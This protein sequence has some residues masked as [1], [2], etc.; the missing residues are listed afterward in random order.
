MAKRP[1]WSI[2]ND[3]VISEDFEF[4]WSGGFALVQ[5]QKNIQAL[6][7]SIMQKCG[8]TALEVSSKSTIPLGK[9][10]GAFSLKWGGIPLE[11]IFQSAKKYEKAGPFTDLLEASSKEAKQDERHHGSGKLVAFIKDDEVWPL[12]PKTAF[13]DYIY[14]KALTE[15]YGDAFDLNEYE[16]FTDIEFN[17]KKSINCQARSAAIYKLLQKKKLFG[18]LCGMERW[19]AFHHKY[20]KDGV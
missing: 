6:H 14:I 3:V 17:P 13:Y 12:E 15:N 8:E 9:D 5:K 16:W 7:N 19:I 4:E 20:V 11:S 1:A 18:E 10:I 2:K